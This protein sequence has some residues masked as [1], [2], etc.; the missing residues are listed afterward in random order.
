[1]KRLFYLKLITA[2]MM[3]LILG[4]TQARATS[5]T[6]T[7][8]SYQVNPGGIVEVPLTLDNASGLAAVQVQI[9]FDPELLE[10]LTVSTGPLGEAFALSHGAGDGF[11]QL[12]F[13][14]ADMLAGGAGRLA[15]LKFRSNSG[16][17]ANQFSDL[18]I[19]DLSFSDSTGVIDLQQTEVLTTTNGQIVV[20][21]Q[22]NID[23]AD[24]GLPDWWEVQHGLDLF[25]A[26]ANLDT[27]KDGI[28]NLMEYACGG[29]PRVSDAKERQV[30]LSRVVVNGKTYLGVGFYRRLGDSSLHYK[31]QESSDLGSWNDLDLTQQTLNVPQNIGDGTE[32]VNV[33]GTLQMAGPNSQSR[34]FLRIVVKRP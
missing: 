25:T 32:F 23:N 30:L 27:D 7:L 18:A 28:S 17:V 10:F 1:M 33:F 13:V 20:S 26:N 29:N 21:L 12:T 5:R 11:V 22:Q 3:L 16:A 2:G 9:N 34:G 14:R 4:M 24:N 31:L 19:A 8:P 6:L 15:V